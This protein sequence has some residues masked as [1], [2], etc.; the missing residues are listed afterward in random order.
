MTNFADGG[1]VKVKYVVE[2]LIFCK[3]RRKN[4]AW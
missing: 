2:L 4:E 1:C 3:R